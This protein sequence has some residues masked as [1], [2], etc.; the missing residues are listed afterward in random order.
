MKQLIPLIAIGLLASSCNFFGDAEAR[1]AGATVNR[2]FQVG[3]FD[4]IAVSGPYEV[5]VKTGG[6]PGVVAHGGSNFLDE[7]EIVVENG[8]LEIRTKKGKNIHW[9]WHDDSKVRIE[10]SAAALHKA[11]IAG[12]GGISIDRVAGGD[13]KGDVAGSGKLSI[14]AIDAA[15]AA[16]AVAGSGDVSAVGKAQKVD[17]SIAGSGDVDVSGLEAIDASVSIAGSGNVRARATGNADVSI[18]GSGDV[19]MTGGAKCNVSKAG[20]GDVRCS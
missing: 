10:V 4:K 13:F 16:F 9:N 7:T 3:A 11:A 1:D 8:T 12:S 15:S 17:I 6:Q 5:T 14:A 20:S 2:T 19:E 18:M